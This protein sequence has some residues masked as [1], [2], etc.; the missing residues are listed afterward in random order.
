MSLFSIYLV[1]NSVPS[2]S[3]IIF[4]K[5]YP[6]HDP[7]DAPDLSLLSVRCQKSVSIVV[8]VV[9]TQVY[10]F[11]SFVWCYV[12]ADIYRAIPFLNY[13]GVLTNFSRG[14]FEIQFPRGSGTLFWISKGVIA[15]QIASI[16]V[17]QALFPRNH[18]ENYKIWPSRGLTTIFP[19]GYLAS[20]FSRGVHEKSSSIPLFNFFLE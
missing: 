10:K 3:G 8:L 12:M 15:P 13:T 17:F 4:V 1:F 6:L 7:D 16:V 5:T 20:K 18:S 14:G 2:V 11:L 19:G 9:K